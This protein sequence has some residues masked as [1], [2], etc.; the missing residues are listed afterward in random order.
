MVDKICN[1]YS[2]CIKF[3][4]CTY[5]NDVSKQYLR[6]QLIKKFNNLIF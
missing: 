3:K 5:K 1:W 2:F 6:A 4:K